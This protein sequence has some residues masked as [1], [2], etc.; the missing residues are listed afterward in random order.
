[1]IRRA[2]GSSHPAI[3]WCQADVLSL[4]FANE[5]FTTI[6]CAFGVRNLQDLKAGLEEMHRILSPGGRAIIL[7]FSLP[8]ARVPRALFYFY[9]NHMLPAIATLISRDRSGAYRYLPRSVLRFANRGQ[10]ANLL[11][12][13][14][15]DRIEVHPLTFGIAVVYLAAKA[16]IHPVNA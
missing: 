8:S 9:F 10:I 4:P 6:S 13:V 2:A 5:T 12:E 1:M 3:L 14:G 11:Q 16:H 7:E 15:F